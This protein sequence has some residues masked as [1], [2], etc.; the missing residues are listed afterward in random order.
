MTESGAVKRWGKSEFWG[1][2]YE[3]DPIW[4]WSKEDI[5]LHEELIEVCRT[6][7]RPNGIDVDKNYTFPRKNLEA[8]AKLRL[9]AL[10]APKEIGGRGGNHVTA[11][12]VVETIG[13]YGCPSTA[14]VYVMHL[15]GC[16]V[17]LYFHH[18]NDTVKDLFR[19]MDEDVLVGTVAGSDPASGGH[20]WFNISA[21]SRWLEDGER[22]QI[23]KYASWITSS[24]FA[25]WYAVLT[26]SP[27]QDVSQLCWFLMY[28]DEV[29]ANADDWSG[30]G[31]RGN[32][33]GPAVCEG[34]LSKDRIIGDTG[35]GQSTNSEITVPFFTLFKAATYIGLSMNCID[36][37]KKHVTRKVH[38]DT[39]IT[40][41]EYPLIQDYVGTSVTRVSASRL[42]AY[43]IARLFDDL[44]SDGLWK[45]KSSKRTPYEGWCLQLVVQ[46]SEVTEL[47]SAKMLHA[48]G[49]AGFKTDLGLEK[50]VRDA[51]ACWVMAPSVEVSRNVIGVMALG[52]MPDF[53]DQN[54]NTHVMEHEISKLDTEGKK[55]AP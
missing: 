34:I 33:S 23:L 17:L 28:A 15:L 46:A 31:M 36:I 12:M 38:G 52:M 8:L 26:P 53:Y 30:L 51:K 50:L 1:L 13:R 6:V 25:D 49:G 14:M 4:M 21:K 55:K 40:V 16:S 10:L 2:G 7:I 19:R 42:M 32:H 39:G 9:L 27:S 37:C 24:G 44:H 35:T 22:I 43:N 45:E 11:T 3:F 41:A 47:V 29:R 48:C 20:F 54:V 18:N 5:A